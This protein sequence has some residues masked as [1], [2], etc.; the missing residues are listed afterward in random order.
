MGIQQQ[1][2][3]KNLDAGFVMDAACHIHKMLI[4]E[5]AEH[6]I[7]MLQMTSGGG[8]AAA[9]TNEQGETVGVAH[10]FSVSDQLDTTDSIQ[11]STG[12]D[13]GGDPKPG[14]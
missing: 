10:Y 11:V 3:A 9:I 7:R 8:R 13:E 14:G 12:S 4:T 2:P 1:E 5:T 6:A